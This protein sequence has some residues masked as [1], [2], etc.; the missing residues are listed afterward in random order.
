MSKLACQV[1]L[2]IIVIGF[3]VH[4]VFGQENSE[5]AQKQTQ[6]ELR[7]RYKSVVGWLRTSAIPIKTVEAEQ[8]FADLQPLKQVLANVQFVGLGEE[9]HGTREF[10]QIKHRLLEFLVREMDVR[11]FAIEGSYAALQ[12]INDYVM[13]RND[14]GAKAL[15]SQRFWTWNTEEV[16]AMMDWARR[17]NTRVES[18]KRVKFVGVDIQYNQP[19]KDRILAY[20][21]RVAP[22]RVAA[23]EAL[24]RTDLD[25]LNTVLE[26][27]DRQRSAKDSLKNLRVHYGALQRFLDDNKAN[28]VAKSSQAEHEQICEYVR[29][30]MQYID[31][32]SLPDTAESA[33]RDNYMA[34]NF[35][36][37]VDQEPTGTRF[38]LWAHN[39]HIATGSTNSFKPLGAR[40]R[41]L[42]GDKYYA[43]GFSFNQ[44]SFQARE[45]QS[46]DSLKGML[47]SFTVPP[48][49]AGSVDWYLTYT[50]QKTCIVDWRVTPKN[51]DVM[52][53]LKTP[54]L[55]RSVGAI[56]S[57]GSDTSYFYPIILSQQ[58][59]GLLFIDSTTRAR[60]NPSVKQVADRTD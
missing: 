46:T 18:N 59:D 48:A 53:W 57:A 35:R 29:V 24:F 56:Y 26:N 10:F 39:V 38:V 15:D 6:A 42:Y 5:S 12:N 25:L 19:G 40:L 32:H 13:G 3:A 45:A 27:A 9:T 55:M 47:T 33:A 60:P 41:Q 44:G 2:R 7:R 51:N 34:E 22:V 52:D 54:C 17:Y 30:I 43:L 21:K 23:T 11:V 20:L 49:L 28:L 50:R 8:G 37:F 16:R 31:A 14:D 1:I 4:P 58:F 36:R